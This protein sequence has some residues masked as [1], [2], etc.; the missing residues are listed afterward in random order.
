MQF[1]QLWYAKTDFDT[2]TLKDIAFILEKIF[3]SH[4]TIFHLLIRKNVKIIL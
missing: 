1:D 4:D 2:L 3:L